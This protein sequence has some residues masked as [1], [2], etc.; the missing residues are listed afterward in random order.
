M[1]ANSSELTTAGSGTNLKVGGE[2]TSGTA[3]Q[4]Q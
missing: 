4:V 1:G 3:I 2:Q